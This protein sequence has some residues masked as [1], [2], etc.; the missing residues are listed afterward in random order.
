M[1]IG[2]RRCAEGIMYGY[3]LMKIVYGKMVEKTSVIAFRKS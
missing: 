3:F 1:D 2:N